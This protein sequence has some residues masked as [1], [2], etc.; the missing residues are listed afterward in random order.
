MYFGKDGSS[1]I[2]RP[3]RRLASDKSRTILIAEDE[4]AVLDLLA[5]IL[6][7]EGYSVLKARHGEEA[8]LFSREFPGDIHLLMTDYRMK[9]DM[10]GLELS[11]RMRRERPGIRILFVSGF[12]GDDALLPELEASGSRFMHK[13]FLPK[14]LLENVRLAL[15]AAD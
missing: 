11:R 12:V 14:A 4:P 1:P 13:P 15:E 8:L 3:R 9:P 6:E 2:P 5:M 10:N 7:M